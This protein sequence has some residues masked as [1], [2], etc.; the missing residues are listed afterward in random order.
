MPPKCHSE[1]QCCE[2][3]TVADC[4]GED[5][6]LITFARLRVTGRGDNPLF[7]HC[8]Q[9]C[10]NRALVVVRIETH[11]PH[12]G[13]EILCPVSDQNATDVDANGEGDEGVQHDFKVTEFG[14]S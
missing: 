12:K 2:S 6:P 9:H 8:H 3:I 13:G 5:K 11:L 10:V 7:L 14:E 1:Y 4:T